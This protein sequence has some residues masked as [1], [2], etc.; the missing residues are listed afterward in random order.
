MQIADEQG[1]L[2]LNPTLNCACTSSVRI[3]FMQPRGATNSGKARTRVDS[4]SSSN[5]VLS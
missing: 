2:G 5:T 1:Q 4:D 3:S